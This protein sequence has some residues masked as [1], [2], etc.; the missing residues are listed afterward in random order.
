MM[1]VFWMSFYFIL[2]Y[3]LG[4]I[5]SGLIIGKVF[6]DIDIR[7]HGSKNTGATNAIRVLGFKYGNWAFVFD[8][9]KGAFVI[10]ILS[11]LKLEDF[12]LFTV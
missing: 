11:F 4:S 9:A 1:I 5:P 2:S 7:Q 8:V 3:I 10:A 6:K 12:Y